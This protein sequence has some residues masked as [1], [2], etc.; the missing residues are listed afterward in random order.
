[1]IDDYKLYL[2]DTRTPYEY[3]WVIVRT[4]EEF[5]QTISEFGLPCFVSFDHDL[6][7]DKSGYDCAKWLI[8]YC[9]KNKLEFPHF[10]IHSMNP[11]GALN[12]QKL[13]DSYRS[14]ALI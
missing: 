4:Y 2:D 1:M 7:E 9:I 13:I 8:D 5:T 3:D 12:I 6:G 14:S 10:K 11:V